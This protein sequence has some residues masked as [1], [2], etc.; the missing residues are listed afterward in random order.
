MMTTTSIQDR[1]ERLEARQSDLARTA[2]RWRMVSMLLAGA[3]LVGSVLGLAADPPPSDVLRAKRIEILND[4]GEPVIFLDT[5]LEGGWLHASNAQGVTSF[6]ARVDQ[7]QAGTVGVYDANGQRSVQL[8]VGESGH[9]QVTTQDRRGR[10]MVLLTGQAAGGTI[11]VFNATGSAVATT[12]VSASGA[13]E[14]ARRALGG[15]WEVLES[16]AATDGAA[17]AADDKKASQPDLIAQEGQSV[18]YAISTTRPDREG[19]PR[20]TQ[21]RYIITMLE[22]VKSEQGPAHWLE[23]VRPGWRGEERLYRVLILD[24]HLTGKTN[25]FEHILQGFQRSAEGDVEEFDE[26]MMGFASRM[27]PPIP[28]MEKLTDRGTLTIEVA[29]KS[30]ETKVKEGTAHTQTQD[31]DFQAD[32][33][34]TLHVSSTVPFKLVKGDVVTKTNWRGRDIESH[35]TLQLETIESGVA[36]RL[37]TEE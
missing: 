35:V 27:L 30:I 3:V 32:S 13:G 5:W 25:P 28:W 37:F 2:N 7:S 11:D 24:E 17:D 34:G 14:L 9:G 16:V 36:S 33:V 26:R 15:E 21:G 8:G 31:G 4:S 23:I 10:P 18:T 22:G 19:Q 29:G 20:T 1:I 12:R 6:S